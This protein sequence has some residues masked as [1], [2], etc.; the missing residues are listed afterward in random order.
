MSDIKDLMAGLVKISPYTSLLEGSSYKRE[1]TDTGS[2]LLNALMSGS[3]YGGVP[4]G[5]V[6]Q[7]A[8]PSPDL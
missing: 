8:G 5:R 7:F 6:V 2:M 4:N 3:V 1:W